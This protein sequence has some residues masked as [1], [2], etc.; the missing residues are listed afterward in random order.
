MSEILIICLTSFLTII[1]GVIVYT[2]TQIVIGPINE[3]K[4]TIGEIADALIFY[5][6]IYS[7]PADLT[8][9]DKQDEALE[10]LRQLAALLQSKTHLIP[11]YKLFETLRIVHNSYAIEDASATL[12]GLSNSIGGRSSHNSQHIQRYVDRIKKQLNLKI[13]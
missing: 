7:A 13:K 6:N 9:K 2:L 3:Q 10:R 5:A 11:R 12:I 4:R 1:G 8:H